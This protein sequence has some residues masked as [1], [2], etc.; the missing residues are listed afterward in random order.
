ML[1]LAAPQ[2]QSYPKGETVCRSSTSIFCSSLQVHL[3][4][5]GQVPSDP[6]IS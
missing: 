1:G 5:L 4:I 3:Q 2:Y 6:T